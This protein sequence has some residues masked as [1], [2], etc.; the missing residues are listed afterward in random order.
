MADALRPLATPMLVALF[1][2]GGLLVV[3]TD[4]RVSFVALL[5]EY[6][7]VAVLL[8]QLVLFEVA[9]VKL[10]VGLLVVS[11]LTLTGWQ[12]NFGRP[13][14]TGETLPLGRFW[15]QPMP[16]GLPFRLMA[17]LMA[18]VA[19]TYIA[20]QP[21]LTL[22]GLDHA[23]AANT[24]SYLLMALGLVNLGLTAEPINAGMGLLTLLIGFEIFYAAV[25]PSLAV[26]ALLAGVHF[27]VALGVSYLAVLQYGVGAKAT[28]T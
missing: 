27:G 8:T 10:L 3:V 14:A 16:T 20:S 4:W 7:G 25:E 23:P 26:V 13:P 5:A 6:I 24:A 15:A 2:A 17:A 18:V 9:V 1:I 11:V 12:L 28:T 21:Q 19:A 22:P